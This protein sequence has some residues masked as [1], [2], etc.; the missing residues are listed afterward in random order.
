MKRII[1]ILLLLASLLVLPACNKF[2]EVEI[3]GKSDQETFFAELDGLRAALPGAYRV[4]YNFY[5]SEFMKYGDIAG[6][7]L[8]MSNV[9]SSANMIDQYNFTSI[10]LQETSA[11]GYI[12][13]RGYIVMSNVNNILEYAPDLKDDYPHNL[14]EINNIM[15][16]AYFLRALMYLDLSL[17]YAQPYNY[18][19]D[20]SHWGV[21]VLTRVP[22]ANDPVLRGTMKQTYQR[23]LEDLDLALKSFTDDYAFDPYYAS[24]LACKA[25]LARVYLYMEKWDIAEKYASEVIDVKELTS[26]ENYIDM[27]AQNNVGEEAIFRLSGYDAGKSNSKFYEYGSATAFP[28][29]TLYS[30]FTDER[31]IRMNLLYYKPETK[32]GK[33]CMKYYMKNTAD[34]KEV[35][36]PFVLRVSEM[37]LI[38]AEARMKQ[39]LLARAADDIKV[40]E[41]RALGIN[42]DEVA[43]SYTDAEDMD[44]LI[45]IESIKEL[46][47]EGHRFFDIA[48]QKKD[49]IREAGTS[50]N[51]KHL[52]Y[53]DY[54]YALPI[55]LV[56]RD[57]N[58]AIQQN[59]G[60]E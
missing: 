40:L 55:S 16:Q 53:P 15:A 38:R 58:P 47:F 51:M 28:A 29:D 2:L 1:Y 35:T 39:G 56:E 18:T 9:T 33:V 45:E 57:A 22:S 42:P 24:P 46:C 14:D 52:E 36:D 30:L 59:E 5:D 60:Y 31:D 20:A 49:V 8:R 25:L 27:Y 43:L 11:V 48:R 37:Y 17:C 4:T 50:S 10:P 19:P 23:I 13:K 44:R 34:I 41:G 12:W 3:L 54:R 21:P 32:K 6:N 26:R 7:M